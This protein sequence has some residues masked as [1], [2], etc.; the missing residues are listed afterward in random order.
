MPDSKN[1]EPLQKVE[2]ERNARHPERFLRAAS[3][4]SSEVDRT[5]VVPPIEPWMDEPEGLEPRFYS[6]GDLFLGMFC[7]FIAGV[8]VAVLAS[9]IRPLWQ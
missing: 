8:L 4:G 5:K 3:L 7:T 1:C 6:R 9:Y 2:D